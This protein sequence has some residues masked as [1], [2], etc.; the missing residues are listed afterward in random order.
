MWQAGCMAPGDTMHASLHAA[1]SIKPKY[2]RM[3]HHDACLSLP[4]PPLCPSMQIPGPPQ[5]EAEVLEEL[6]G[7]KVLVYKMRPK[8][9]YR[10]TQG[11]RQELTKFMVTSITTGSS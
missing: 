2:M 3:H 5:V 6:R 10:R 8:K 7:P 4:H 9:H 11:H 1:G